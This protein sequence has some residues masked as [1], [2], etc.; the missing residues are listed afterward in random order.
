MTGYFARLFANASA[1]P[2]AARP[3]DEIAPLV[4]ENGEVVAP[5]PPAAAPQDRQAG[6][7][8]SI[9]A[10]REPAVPPAQPQVPAEIAAAALE[11]VGL[12]LPPGPTSSSAAPAVAAHPADA[13]REEEATAPAS[14]A[15]GLRER[16]VPPAPAAVPSG[17]DRAAPVVRSA[18]P[19]SSPSA[20]PASRTPV[21]A[22]R[23]TAQPAPSSPAESSTGL[24]A[25]R[26]PAPEEPARR[27]TGFI[28][29]PPAQAPFAA[30]RHEHGRIPF[31]APE[32][33]SVRIGTL[34]M[35]VHAPPALSL[36]QP[37][38]PPAPAPSRPPALRRFY[39][40]GV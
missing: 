30:R 8:A 23:G 29:P 16:A 20:E 18:P 14:R 4:E 38:V 32:P 26:S 34:R 3:G 25:V 15:I 17:P 31:G 27:A 1:R 9:R 2:P 5:A 37:S 22:Q 19:R 35:E 28:L 24:S 21:E 13:P 11:R 12:Q 6:P 39:V 10:T 36:S 40:R 33:P 7:V